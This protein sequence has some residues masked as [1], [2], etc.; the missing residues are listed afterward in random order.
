MRSIGPGADHGRRT[1]RFAAPDHHQRYAQDLSHL[2]GD[3]GE[4][5]RRGRAAG[6]ERRDP[7]QRRLLRRQDRVVLAQRAFGAHAVVDVGEGHNRATA[8][9]HLD[10][11]REVGDREHRPVATDEPV[12]IA[13]DPLAGRMGEQHRAVR[14]GIR[15]AV[16]VLV[17]DRLVAL[18]AEQLVRTVVA[19][20]RDRGRVGEPDQAIGI[21]D[22]DRLR[23]G[24]EHGPEE[25]LGADSQAG[26][27][28]QRTGHAVVSDC[29]IESTRG[30]NDGPTRPPRP[31]GGQAA[32][33]AVDRA[34]TT[35]A[36]AARV[37]ARRNAAVARLCVSR[38]VS[39]AHSI[40][41]SAPSS[42]TKR[43]PGVA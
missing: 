10:G 18:A 11:H 5:D 24:F 12:E 16:G 6:D 30:A 40:A 2:P 32:S 34:A 41:G 20:C 33:A 15:A 8:L 38:R 39:A 7:A 14:S 25:V 29:S 42:G 26:H 4:H 9:R 37:R 43:T 3:G 36:R 17:V 19:E 35:R 28:D 31:A 21:H 1:V 27:V 13:R 23:S 22:P